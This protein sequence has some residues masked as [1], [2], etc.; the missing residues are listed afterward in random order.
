MEKEFTPPP[1]TYVDFVCF[2]VD[3]AWRRLPEEVRRPAVEAFLGA[4]NPEGVEVR[5]YLT[6]GL[7]TDS[8]FLLWL[9][10]K[11]LE[12]IQEYYCSLLRLEL[13]KY[14]E[15]TYNWIAMTK[16][17]PYSK[18]HHQR[19]EVSKQ[20]AKWLFIYPFTKTHEWYQLPFEERRAMMVQ[21]NKIGHRFPGVLINTCYS[22]GL[23][24]M[25]FMLAFEAEDPKEFSDLV[26]E[27]RSSKAR[28]YTM[29]DVPI[30]PCRMVTPGEMAKSLGL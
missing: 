3:P 22:F 4:L 5:T 29:N 25:E 21:H 27:L 16:S 24:D 8:D 14:L 12:K 7:R 1:P 30:M 17:T 6:A 19:F 10:G 18:S 28:P 2:K 23:D 15:A 13:G 26:Q 20:T 9:I 11:D